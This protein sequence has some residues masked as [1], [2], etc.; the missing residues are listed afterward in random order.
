[1]K[2]RSILA[3]VLLPLLSIRGDGT[4][5]L[6]ARQTGELAREPRYISILIGI[7][8]YRH[9]G[10]TGEPGRTDLEGPANDVER[11]QFAL[12]RFGFGDAR[13]TR[14]LRDSQAT[15]QGIASVFGWLANVATDSSDVVVI[16]YAGHGSWAPDGVDQDESTITRGDT[17]DEALVP[18]DASEIHASEQLILDDQIRAW[19]GELRT[20]NVTVIVDACHSGTI[21]RGEGHGVR[22]RGP[23]APSGVAL[24][25]PEGTLPAASLE[26]LANPRHVLITAS[27]ADQTSIEKYFPA[28]D[29]T[30]GVFTESFVRVLNDASGTV[31]YDELLDRVRTVLRE[32]GHLQ[33]PQVEGD[34]GALL[35]RVREPLAAKPFALLTPLDSGRYRLDMGARHGIRANAV[36]DVHAPEDTRLTGV[37][38]AQLRI[39][40]IEESASIGEALS[41]A[42]ITRGARAVLSRI[43]LG[44]RSLDTLAVFVAPEARGLLPVLR[45][46][47]DLIRIVADS[48]AAQSW[49]TIRGNHAEVLFNGT[50]L[51]PR[52]GVPTGNHASG[53]CDR[54]ARA[55]ALSSLELIRN[56]VEVRDFRVQVRF[57]KRGAPVPNRRAGVDTVLVDSIYDILAR[58]DAPGG[59][60]S[61]QLYLTAVIGGYTDRVS[62]LWPR[63]GAR[64]DPFTLDE[65]VPLALRVR[66]T[67]PLGTDLVKVVVNSDQFDFNPLVASFPRCRRT[68]DLFTRGDGDDRWTSD[69]QPVTGWVSLD[70]RV[71]VTRGTPQNR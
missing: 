3:A 24:N 7:S 30:M 35:F 69:P 70:H 43:P 17:L 9:F 14:V 59:G 49:I 23:L 16:F 57:V 8:D 48:N 65:W 15:R 47:F 31:R 1:M 45:D 60:P 26:L 5:A 64:N 71:V 28:D 20:S 36:F 58:I 63:G 33:T 10:Q 2:A 6:D 27:R 39:G 12:R 42:P 19:L 52:P 34:R 29:R 50:A 61:T 41:N 4:A 38:V 51:P 66:I 46:S 68:G 25:N 21:S 13:Y 22:S 54:L 11:M 55:F 56:P 62:V 18:H 40:A 44:A 67:E 53:L 37:P 32:A